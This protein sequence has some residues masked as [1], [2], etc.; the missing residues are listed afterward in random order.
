MAQILRKR[1]WLTTLGELLLEG[2]CGNCS[3]I[4]VLRMAEA[5]ETPDTVQLW[6]QRNLV[7]AWSKVSCLHVFADEA[8]GFSEDLDTK[9][10]DGN[11][12][13]Q[14]LRVVARSAESL[15]STAHAGSFGGFSEALARFLF[16]LVWC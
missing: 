14:S 1:E 13:R 2:S 5:R 7:V 6:W 8:R 11:E 15:P 10:V 4:P 9:L 3:T 12:F 16:V